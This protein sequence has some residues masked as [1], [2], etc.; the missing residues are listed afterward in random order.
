MPSHRLYSI[1]SVLNSGSTASSNVPNAR[2]GSTLIAKRR[3]VARCEMAVPDE[4]E[5]GL[6]D[7]LGEKGE[8]VVAF[9][10]LR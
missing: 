3:E 2:F 6:L 7:K 9:A 4:F 8:T 1:F 5:A 10:L